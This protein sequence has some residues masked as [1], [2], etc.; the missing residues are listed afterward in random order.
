MPSPGVFTTDGRRELVVDA[1]GPARVL[2]GRRLDGVYAD[3][4][5]LGLKVAGTGGAVLLLSLAAG[6]FLA[7][8]ALA[9][10]ARI[11]KTAGAMIGGDLQARIPVKDTDSELEQVAR[12]LN[13]AFDRMQMAADLQRQFTADASHEFRTPLATLRAE[14]DWALKRPRSEEEYRG[15]IEKGQQAVQRLTQI[16]DRLLTLLRPTAHAST[17]QQVDLGALLH[18]VVALLTPLAQAHDVR[19]HANVHHVAVTGDRGLLV[20][21]FSNLIKNGVEYNHPSGDVFVTV[22][23]EDTRALVSIRDTGVGIAAEDLPHIFERFYRAERSRS[24][25]VG[26]AGLGLAIV[27]QAIE[28]HGGSVR[29]SSRPGV[30]TEFLVTLPATNAKKAQETSVS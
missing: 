23:G 17:R 20:D 18:E 22:T 28:A 21:A 2:V 3:L 24:R 25:Q 16:A 10:V 29:C 13:E 5:S 26:G 11:N 15:S 8:R 12:A 7:G 27:K 6:S 19:I 9:P 4:R 14:F 1:P 30:G